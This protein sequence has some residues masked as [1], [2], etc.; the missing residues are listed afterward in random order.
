[1][2]LLTIDFWEGNSVGKKRDLVNLLCTN[3]LKL[4]GEWVG[5]LWLHP[6]GIT[7]LVSNPC[8]ELIKRSKTS[9][10]LTQ[11]R[12]KPM[13]HQP[14]TH[15]QYF[16]IF[17]Q[18]KAAPRRMVPLCGNSIDMPCTYNKCQSCCVSAAGLR[19]VKFF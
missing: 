9:Q 6:P 13:S 2:P 4:W 18:G 1:M 17:T 19:S 3:L 11:H 15:S 16:Q 14:L 5:P 10:D 12:T 7:S 8:N